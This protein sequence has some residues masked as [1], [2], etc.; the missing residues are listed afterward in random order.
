VSA[1]VLVV[2]DNPLVRKALRH[3]LES[4]PWEISE[5]EDGQTA[6]ARALELRPHVIVLDLVMPVMDGLNAAREIS[7]ALPETAIVMYSMH[8]SPLL[9]VEAQKSGVR[10]LVSKSQSSVLLATI[11]E[12][13]A[14]VPPDSASAPAVSDVVPPLVLSADSA[15]APDSEKA[16]T[17]AKT[18]TTKRADG[19]LAS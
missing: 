6:V 8:A 17:N 1:R 9:E 4:G 5:A 10:K 14:G 13:V 16:A 18:E 7:Q 12:L 19:E 11:H 2:D 3:L 15:S